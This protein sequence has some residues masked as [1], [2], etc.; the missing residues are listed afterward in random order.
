MK[1]LVAFLFGGVLLLAACGG[2]AGGGPSATNV[3]NPVD[4]P[5]SARVLVGGSPLNVSGSQIEAFFD[6]ELQQA[7]TLLAENH[8]L[9]RFFGTIRSNCRGTVCNTSNGRLSVSDLLDEITEIGGVRIESDSENSPVMTYR[10]IPISQARSDVLFPSIP[11]AS[12]VSSGLGGWL[13]YGG[14]SVSAGAVFDGPRNQQIPLTVAIGQVSFGDSAGARPAFGATRTVTWE[15]AMVAA[16]TE[17]GHS[18]IAASTVR[19][20]LIWMNADV[21]MSNVVDMDARARLPSFGWTDLPIE[22]NGTFGDGRT[23]SASF[24]GPNHEEVGGIFT[25]R[26]LIGAF[27]ADRQ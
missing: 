22:A 1:L 7:D 19:V 8:D 20:D 6:R 16:D 10:G 2:G 23:L 21:Q 24:Y 18:I 9:D 14:F 26:D 13:D 3:A 5:E 27:G 4:D 17:F 25:T 15:G 11:H 12:L